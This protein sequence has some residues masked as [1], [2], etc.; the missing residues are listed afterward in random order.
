MK[1]LKITLLFLL[2]PFIFSCEKTEPS[3]MVLSC[4][5]ENWVGVYA[6]HEECDEEIPDFITIE[7]TLGMGSEIDEFIY[8]GKTVL[9]EECMAEVILLDSLNNVPKTVSFELLDGDSILITS[10][11]EIPSLGAPSC[12]FWGGK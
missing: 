3:K 7:R 10:T 6:G 2:T 1:N 9:F 4:Q 5:Q 12:R 11:I 8:E